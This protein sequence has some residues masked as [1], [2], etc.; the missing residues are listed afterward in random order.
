MNSVFFILHKEFWAV[1]YYEKV[2]DW[3]QLG[4]APPLNER[5]LGSKTYSMV[6]K[7]LCLECTT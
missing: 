4:D 5:R 6:N 7:G 1:N 3:N 2:M